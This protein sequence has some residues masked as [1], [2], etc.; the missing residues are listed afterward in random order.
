[1]GIA[2]SAL[3]VREIVCKTFI[4][5]IDVHGCPLELKTRRSDKKGC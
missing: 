2:V 4:N 1:M 3:D 5:K